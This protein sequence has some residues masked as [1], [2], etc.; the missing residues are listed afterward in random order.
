MDSLKIFKL[1][2]RALEL[3]LKYIIRRNRST[4]RI[5]MIH[6]SATSNIFRKAGV[7]VCG[8][9]CVR[10]TV[11]EHARVYVFM[12]TEPHICLFDRLLFPHDRI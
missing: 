3:G 10:E 6:T 11:R 2:M 8:C 5:A 9:V 7:T 12:N 4:W 1:L